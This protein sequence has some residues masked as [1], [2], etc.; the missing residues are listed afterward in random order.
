[1]AN[2]YIMYKLS[3]WENHKKYIQ[4]STGQLDVFLVANS[5]FGKFHYS[6]LS[7]HLW[8]HSHI[9]C[10]LKQLYSQLVL[11]TLTL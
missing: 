4:Q 10:Y 2:T 6:S 3:S 8:T 5:N 7:N 11:S 1:M 9:V